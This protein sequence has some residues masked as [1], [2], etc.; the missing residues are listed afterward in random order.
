[1]SFDLYFVTPAEDGSFDSVMDDLEEAA[2]SE[3]PLEDRDLQWWEEITSA[4]AQVLPRATT[5]AGPRHRE[6]SDDDTGIQLSIHRGE[7]AL[8][9]P[10]WHSGDE[11][12][13]I[14][15]LLVEIARRVEEI[16]GLT[17]YD[18]QAEAP[19]L[20]EGVRTAASTMDQTRRRLA[21]L[22]A[23]ELVAPTPVQPRQRQGFW[24]RLL[25][26]DGR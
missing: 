25:G 14:T 22:V 23:E 20:D 5:S 21:D 13:R 15:S 19:F 2:E 26:R 24:A 3:M 9:V 12:D 8:T 7:L 18:P 17:A 1:M 16:T 10:Y 6:L 11:A 4:L